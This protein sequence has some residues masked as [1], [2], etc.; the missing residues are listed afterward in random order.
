MESVLEDAYTNAYSQNDPRR[1]RIR[2]RI[3]IRISITIRFGRETEDGENIDG[4]GCYVVRLNECGYGC[5][6]F[7]RKPLLTDSVEKCC[8]LY[9]FAL[10]MVM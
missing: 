9:T 3:E 5:C 4:S 1:L 7:T 6:P 10:T 8:E 2:I